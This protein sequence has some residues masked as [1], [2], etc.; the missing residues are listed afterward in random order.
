[1]ILFLKDAATFVERPVE[2]LKTLRQ[3]QLVKIDE[4][5]AP[6]GS[7]HETFPTLRLH[8]AVP[9]QFPDMAALD[10]QRLKNMALNGDTRAYEELAGRANGSSSEAKK[11]I[12]A[13]D[14]ANFYPQR[15][16]LNNSSGVPLSAWS[17]SDQKLL[18]IG[19]NPE[20]HPEHPNI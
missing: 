13:F 16:A 15:P 14:R 20:G 8:Q 17:S 1:M 6:I 3:Q 11:I 9:L 10:N 4:G 19:K 5:S 12:Q 2:S 18:L 7:N